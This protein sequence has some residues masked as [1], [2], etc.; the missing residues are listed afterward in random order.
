MFW[1]VIFVILIILT[2]FHIQSISISNWLKDSLLGKEKEYEVG[3][4]FATV[5]LPNAERLKYSFE[6]YMCG[7]IMEHIP[8]IITSDKMYDFW[9]YRLHSRGFIYS[10]KNNADLP[11]NVIERIDIRSESFKVKKRY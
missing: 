4:T 5:H 1:Y 8:V 7:Y 9:L 6:G 3:K 10:P 11:I 2:L